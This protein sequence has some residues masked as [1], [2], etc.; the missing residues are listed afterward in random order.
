MDLLTRACNFSINRIRRR[1]GKRY[2]AS[3][4]AAALQCARHRQRLNK[5]QELGTRHELSLLTGT[6]ERYFCSII[7][8]STDQTLFQRH[9]AP[10]DLLFRVS[11]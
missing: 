3:F 10:E 1:Y 2:Q 11:P 6:L 8:Q 7:E 4:A 5:W 9:V